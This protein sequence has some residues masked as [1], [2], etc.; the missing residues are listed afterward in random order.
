M[1]MDAK[2]TNPWAKALEIMFLGN[3][4]INNLAEPRVQLKELLKQKGEIGLLLD[5]PDLSADKK[6]LFREELRRQ[7]GYIAA[8]Y[9]SLGELITAYEECTKGE[10]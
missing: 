5:D 7:S 9:D 10:L 1:D 2:H 8:F 4:I 6:E 3:G